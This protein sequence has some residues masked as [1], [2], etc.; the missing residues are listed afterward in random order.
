MALFPGVFSMESTMYPATTASAV[1]ADLHAES[2][3]SWP[4][5][6]AGAVA[7]AALTL[8]LIAFGAG[9]GFSAISPWSDTGVSA[10]TFEVGTGIW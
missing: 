6:A 8:L 5:V 10:S 3:V 2:G 1:V 4:A 9:I 7:A